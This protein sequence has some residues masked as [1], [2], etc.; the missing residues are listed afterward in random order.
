MHTHEKLCLPDAGHGP[1]AE[2]ADKQQ[3]AP[4]PEK[5]LTPVHSYFEH[6]SS[7]AVRPSPATG[8]QAECF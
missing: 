8:F 4:E 1:S 2:E 3:H 7:G 5:Q 6:I